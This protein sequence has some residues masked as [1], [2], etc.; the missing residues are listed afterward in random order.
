MRLDQKATHN[1]PK[2]LLRQAGINSID[3]HGHTVRSCWWR[4]EGGRKK[5]SLWA[6]TGV[7]EADQPLAQR[8]PQCHLG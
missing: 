4:E 7:T 6:N 8:W 3:V 5:R 2:P 1:T